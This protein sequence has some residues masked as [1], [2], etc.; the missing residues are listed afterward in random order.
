MKLTD[1]RESQRQGRPRRG[2][3]ER[4]LVVTGW[5]NKPLP[6]VVAKALADAGV[7]A[8]VS[9]A[10]QTRPATSLF[11]CAYEVREEPPPFRPGD[12]VRR[13]RNGGKGVLIELVSG[14][15]SLWRVIVT[16]GSR[17]NGKGAV[18]TWGES[19]MEVVA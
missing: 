12:T 8:D 3:S 17:N 15:D 1:V 13:R 5:S 7:E 4:Y 18:A 14:C 11:G 6:E 10:R 9:V 2:G 19:F 16:E